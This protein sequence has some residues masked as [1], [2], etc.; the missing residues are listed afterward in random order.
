[1]IGEKSDNK[2]PFLSA[3]VLT[4]LACFVISIVYYL[5]RYAGF[6]D[7]SIQQAT[8]KLGLSKILLRTFVYTIVIMIF[9]VVKYRRAKKLDNA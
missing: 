7:L 5:I 9:L 6:E 8:Q 4:A 1:M 3:F 2:F